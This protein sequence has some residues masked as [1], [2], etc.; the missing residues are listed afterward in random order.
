MAYRGRTTM[1]MAKWLAMDLQQNLL[2]ATHQTRFTGK[3][4][5]RTNTRKT[6]HHITKITEKVKTL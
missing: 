4:I 3:T 5:H 6:T 2:H 1:N